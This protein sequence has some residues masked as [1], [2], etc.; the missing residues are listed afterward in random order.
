MLSGAVQQMTKAERT[1]A[2]LLSAAREVFEDAP[3]ADVRI[4]WIARGAGVSHGTF[5]THFDSKEQIFSV[6]AD[7]LIE[8]IFAASR[9]G[10]ATLVEPRQRIYAANVHYLQAIESRERLLFRLH[11]AAAVEE[12]FRARL[13]RAYDMF[14]ERIEHG[15]ARMQAHGLANPSLRARP[16]VRALAAM[17]ENFA[18]VWVR[19]KEGLARDEAAAV[20]TELWSGAIGLRD[21]PP[22]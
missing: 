22:L 1:R 12:V 6:L 16:T 4:D 14:Y 11:E 9:V 17:V 13:D 15:L 20:L 18:L 10:D 21:A 19:S 8:E 2:R 3:Y 7:E 5:Y